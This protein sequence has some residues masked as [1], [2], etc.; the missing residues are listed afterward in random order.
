MLAL[1]GAGC[2]SSDFKSQSQTAQGAEIGAASGA[3]L[4]G[5]VGHQSGEAT[6]GAAVGAAVGGLAGAVIGHER[7]RRADA[8]AGRV[9]DTAYSV[10]SIPPTPTSQPYEQMPPQPSRDAVWI[11][12]HYEYT[13]SGYQWTAGRWEVPPPGMHTWIEPTWQ[14]NPNGSGYVYTRGHWQ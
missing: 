5:V 8:A 6:K 13:G 3:A 9:G 7:E 14:P 1:L 2:S 12:G 10:Q 11:R 4:G